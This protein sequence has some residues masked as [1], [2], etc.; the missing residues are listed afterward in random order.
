MR[1][2]RSRF[3]NLHPNFIDALIFYIL[4]IC[5][6]KWYEELS[7]TRSP[8]RDFRLPD[9]GVVALGPN[10]GTVAEHSSCS[11]MLLGF[12]PMRSGLSNAL[13]LR[14]ESGDFRNADRYDHGG[15]GS[16]VRTDPIVVN[17]SGMSAAN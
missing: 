9:S 7:T 14:R 2:S 5:K 17:T 16:L 4:F 1:Q 8:A 10:L 6:S 11:L 3:G 15:A 13:S 12:V